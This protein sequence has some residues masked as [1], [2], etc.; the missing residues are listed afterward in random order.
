[1]ILVGD[2]AYLVGPLDPTGELV[3]FIH[4]PAGQYRSPNRLASGAFWRIVNPDLS[5]HSQGTDEDDTFGETV[6]TIPNTAYG[7]ETKDFELW[8]FLGPHKH[9][10]VR[11]Q[12]NTW[13]DLTLPAP[14]RP[15]DLGGVIGLPGLYYPFHLRVRWSTAYSTPNAYLNWYF[16]DAFARDARLSVRLPDDTWYEVARMTRNPRNFLGNFSD[17]EA[18]QFE[19]I[20]SGFMTTSPT[21]PISTYGWRVDSVNSGGDPLD[22]SAWTVALEQ[23]K[24]DVGNAPVVQGGYTAQIFSHVVLPERHWVREFVSIDL[25]MVRWYDRVFNP[26][27][28][29]TVNLVFTGGVAATI[30]TFNDLGDPEYELVD[31]EVYLSAASISAVNQNVY[32]FYPF[33][34][35]ELFNLYPRLLHTEAGTVGEVLRVFSTSGGRVFPTPPTVYQTYTYPLDLDGLAGLR[36]LD[37]T[38]STPPVD[39]PPTPAPGGDGGIRSATLSVGGFWEYRLVFEARA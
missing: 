29:Y 27:R 26:Y 32:A 9:L 35:S 16:Q 36:H 12:S 25:D 20:E 23:G 37:F 15:G 24:N 22:V 34:G 1:M 18:F 19:L 30:T 10:Y 38:V 33:A 31:G 4:I 6:I 11:T 2:G 5:I 7:F 8:E 13:F 21:T 28:S 14:F 39:D 3:D 17:H